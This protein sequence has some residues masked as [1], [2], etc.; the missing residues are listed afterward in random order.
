[1]LS[2]AYTLLSHAATIEALHSPS[3]A[4]TPSHA[5]TPSLPPPLLIAKIS[6]FTRAP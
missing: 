2:R 3:H 6:P 4:N 5:K 1:M